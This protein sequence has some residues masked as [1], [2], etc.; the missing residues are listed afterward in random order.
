MKNLAKVQLSNKLE[1]FKSARATAND[2][3]SDVS[4]LYDDLNAV[5]Q[6]MYHCYTNKGKT[7]DNGLF[8]SNV[9]KVSKI[10]SELELQII[11][12]INNEISKIEKEMSQ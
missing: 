5:N 2:L 3:L 4:S 1:L 8:S 10:M 11:P 12:S 9:S 7:M 6:N